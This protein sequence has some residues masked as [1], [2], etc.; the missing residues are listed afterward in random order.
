MEQ[1]LGFGAEGLSQVV[2]KVGKQPQVGLDRIQIAQVEPLVGKVL[3]EANGARIGQHALD[4]RID[5]VWLAQLSFSGEVEK[6]VVWQTAPKE[7]GKSRG[8]F[9]VAHRV[10]TLG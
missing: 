2:V 8:Q 3:G 10:G 5:H 7:K 6:L 4:L 9:D 1:E